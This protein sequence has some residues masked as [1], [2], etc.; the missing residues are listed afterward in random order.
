MSLDLRAWHPALPEGLAR[1]PLRQHQCSCLLQRTQ[2]TCRNKLWW[3]QLPNSAKEK[4]P[5]LF[6]L[7]LAIQSRPIMGTAM[8]L[9]DFAGSSYTTL[10][11]SY[12]EPRPRH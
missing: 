3:A 10:S 6:V 2:Q 11:S 4:E 5:A 12:N 7:A 1:V 8:A 9:V